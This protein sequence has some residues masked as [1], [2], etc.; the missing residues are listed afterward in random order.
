MPA[1]ARVQFVHM[2]DTSDEWTFQDTLNEMYPI[3]PH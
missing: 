3:T 1:L 2:A